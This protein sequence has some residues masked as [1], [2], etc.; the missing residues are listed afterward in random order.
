MEQSFEGRIFYWI[1]VLIGCGILIYFSL[2][3]EPNIG[4]NLL[5]FLVAAASGWLSYQDQKYWRSVIFVIPALVLAGLLLAQIRTQ[6]L[7]TQFIEKEGLYDIAATVK[8]VEPYNKA[9]RIILEDIFV[10]EKDGRETALPASARIRLQSY[11]GKD[12]APGDHIKVLAKLTPPSG[13]VYPEGFDFRRYAYYR[14]LYAVGFTLSPFEILKATTSQKPSSRPF[15]ENLRHVINLSLDQM[16]DK[17]SAGVAKALLTG[18][19]SA[20]SEKTLEAIRD[21]GLAHLLAISGLHVGLVAGFIYFFVRF[22]LAMIPYIALRYPIKKIAAIF[23]LASAIF[24][25]LLVGA[26]VPTQ[27]A[28]LMTGLVFVAILF[29]R[30][31]ISFRLAAFA[32]LLIMLIQ[33]EAIAEV[34]FQLSFSAVLSL[35]AFYEWV[36][37]GRDYKAGANGFFKKWA[38]YFLGVCA[39]TV[40]ASL[41][42]APLTLYHFQHFAAYGVLSNLV[43]VPL[44]SFVIMPLGIVSL[45]A[46]PFQIEGLPLSAMERAIEIIIGVAYDTEGLAGSVWHMPEWPG[47]AIAIYSFGFLLLLITHMPLR[48]ISIPLMLLGLGLSVTKPLPD[49]LVSDDAALV[50]L[51]QD[52]TLLLNNLRKNSY[53]AENWVGSFGLEK[54]QLGALQ[55]CD[56]EACSIMIKGKRVSYVMHHAAIEESCAHSDILILS[57]ALRKD[58]KLCAAPVI[59]DRIDVWRDGAYSIFIDE[60]GFQTI[61]TVRSEAGQRPWA[62]YQ[63]SD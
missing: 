34:S 28:V 58:R 37:K 17:E 35:I 45:I 15:F 25:M 47:Y 12:I 50:G 24:Y 40:I 32:A 31:A 43:A 22:V 62:M 27:R 56:K 20:V 48:I 13:P 14:S 46:M 6:N 19:R 41:A 53:V 44:M 51:H 8:E 30:S 49:I 57:M 59:I 5:L 60:Q 39:T 1:P 3:A 63:K 7:D 23:G 29:D 16:Q 4:I 11:H 55:S 21:A 38:G 10:V 52:G 54:E 18:D 33:P 61:K 9:L 2:S 36:A 26:P 42:T